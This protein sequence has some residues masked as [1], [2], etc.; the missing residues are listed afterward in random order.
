MDHVQ[1]ALESLGVGCVGASPH[2]Q[3]SDDRSCLPGDSTDLIRPDGY[4]APAESRLPFGL[5]AGDQ[6]LLE[7]DPAPRVSGQETHD[8]SVSAGL[9]QLDAADGAQQSIR[10]LYC[11]TG[12][13]ARRRVSPLAPAML[14]VAERLQ[15]SLDGL[16][17][18]VPAQAGHER[19]ATAVVLVGLIIEAVVLVVPEFGVGGRFV[20]HAHDSD[21]QPLVSTR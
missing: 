7:L 5:D 8:H 1:L 3:L 9:R 21:W 15:R 12:A 19:D 14:H 10:H 6:Q 2:E 11:D 20:W 4:V 16:V 18:R 13:I 17:N